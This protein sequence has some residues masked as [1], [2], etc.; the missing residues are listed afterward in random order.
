MSWSR[1]AYQ[2]NPAFPET[3]IGSGIHQ[4]APAAAV[5]PRETRKRVC[6]GIGDTRQYRDE[7]VG[8]CLSPLRLHPE[9]HAGAA[10][11]AVKNCL[12]LTKR[13]AKRLVEWSGLDPD[14]LVNW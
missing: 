6:G 9:G 5:R 14:E 12:N 11:A 7:R 3:G 13:Q 1:Q 2:K 8:P 4:R 10:M